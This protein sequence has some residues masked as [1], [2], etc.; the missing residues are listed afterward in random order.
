M[1]KSI[2]ILTVLINVFVAI[3]IACFIAWL[4]TGCGALQTIAS[5]PLVADTICSIYE[6]MGID[7]ETTT[8]VIPQT[9]KNPCVVR[10]ILDS[11]LQIGST[12]VGSSQFAGSS[13]PPPT[14]THDQITEFVNWLSTTRASLHAG[15]RIGNLQKRVIAT[16]PDTSS[17]MIRTVELSISSLLSTLPSSRT[18]S[19]DDV[20]ILQSSIDHITG[21]LAQV[22]S[23]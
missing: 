3:M 10:E 17:E 23:R 22:G 1:P 9:I 5:N 6:S 18:L 14:I 8:A 16:M 19:S 2:F 20:K 13:A 4:P 11:L 15:E 7:T 12:V 21:L